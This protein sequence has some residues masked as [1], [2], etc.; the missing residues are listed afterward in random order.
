MRHTF[1][2]EELLE[3]WTV[4]PEERL[5]IASKSGAHSLGFA[6]LLKFMEAE[7]RFPRDPYEIPAAVI[8]YVARQLE[9][10][11]DSW[12]AYDW[13]GRT[14][15][16]HRAA[17]RGALGFRESTGADAETI[18]QWA[19]EHVFPHERDLDRITASVLDRYR[20]LRLE[21]PARDH[22]D[23]LVRSAVAGYEERLCSA[24]VA[25]LQPL[26]QKALDD[27]L[28]SGDNT[29]EV[30]QQVRVPLYDLRSEPGKASLETLKEELAKLELLQSMG[31]PSELV[32]ELPPRLLRDWRQQVAVEELFELRRH[33][34]TTRLALLTAYCLV[35]QQ[36]LTDTLVDI[37]LDMVHRIGSRA[38]ERVEK[39]LKTDVRRVNGKQTLLFRLAEAAVARPEG[40]IRDVLFPVVSERILRALV[41]EA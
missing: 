18:M 4:A 5:L 28:R 9:V 11:P 26:C 14:I 10:P 19:A 8:V 38:E 3:K 13:K 35:R 29:A 32:R 1:T 40:T 16:Y 30:E 33:P 36:E 15:K 17:I 34:D 21:P 20:Q 2:E 12:S 31:L 39:K 24:I 41:E 7:G 23:R 22:L 37:L 25:K 6:L 27:L